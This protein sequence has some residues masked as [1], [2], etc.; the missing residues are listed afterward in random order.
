[1]NSSSHLL[2]KK[3]V[4]YIWDIFKLLLSQTYELYQL[5][6]ETKL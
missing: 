5:Y 3:E 4:A 1:M 2:E 6:H